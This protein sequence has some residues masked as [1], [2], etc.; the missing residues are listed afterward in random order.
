MSSSSCC[1]VH[2]LLKGKHPSHNYR[3][4]DLHH[5]TSVWSVKLRSSGLLS[6][7]SVHADVRP[8]IDR[9]TSD[10]SADVCSVW[11]ISKHQMGSIRSIRSVSCSMGCLGSKIKTKGRSVCSRTLF[12]PAFNWTNVLL[13]A[14]FFIFFLLKCYI[15]CLP[16]KNETFPN[17]CY[18]K[19][20][21]S[22]AGLA[23]QMKPWGDWC[24]GEGLMHL[25]Y[26]SARAATFMY[27]DVLSLTGPA[28]DRQT[29]RQT[30][31]GRCKEPVCCIQQGHCE[32]RHL[33]MSC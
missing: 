18:R 31:T 33:K 25:L 28:R 17:S 7:A 23:F 27:R 12:S 21:L 8:A 11:S 3:S 1:L 26:R 32:R 13:N 22:L 14:C 29:D 6:L 9:H 30:V 24:T 5:H 15:F 16:W 20:Q 10:R 2:C 19:S 4:I